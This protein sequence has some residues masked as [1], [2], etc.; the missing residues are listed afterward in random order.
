MDTFTPE[1][2]VNEITVT[3]FYHWYDQC[4]LSYGIAKTKIKSADGLYS[5]VGKSFCL[6][7]LILPK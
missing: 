5:K 2:G 3:G 7:K 6:S 4:Y 1:D